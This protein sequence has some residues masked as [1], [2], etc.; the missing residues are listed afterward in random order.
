MLSQTLRPGEI[1]FIDDGSNDGIEEFVKQFPAIRYHQHTNRGLAASRNVGIKLANGSR[2][3]FLDDDDLLADNCIEKIRDLGDDQLTVGAL[4]CQEFTQSITNRGS[5]HRYPEGQA[6]LPQLFLSTLPVHSYLFPRQLLEK[7]NGFDETLRHSEDWDLW[8]R[9]AIAG[10]RLNYRGEIG[11]YY[12]QHSDTMSSDRFG[13]IYARGKILCKVFSQFH[14]MPQFWSEWAPHF[15]RVLWAT[16][17]HLSLYASRQRSR[18]SEV[19]SV[20]DRLDGIARALHSNNI[21]I[22]HESPK[23][24][25]GLHRLAGP[26]GSLAEK[27]VSRALALMEYHSGRI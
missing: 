1:L 17:R 20:M 19:D 5:V 15:L 2:I 25:A 16:R 23:W 10:A 24:V 11:S 3:L 7:V 27:T 21:R 26:P 9:L 6:W 14:E 18:R 12:R 13:M 4:A 8:L 22:G